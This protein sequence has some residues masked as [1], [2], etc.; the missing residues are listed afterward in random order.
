MSELPRV[1]IAS[2]VEGLPVAEAVNIKL[3]YDVRVKQWDNA[4]DL[5]SITVTSLISRANETDY[6]VFV[7]HKDDK[8]TIRGNQYSVVR[9]NV[10]FELGLF[11]GALGIDHCFL[12]IPKS[13]EGEFRLPTDLAG[14]TTSTYDDDL[15]DMVDAVATSCAKIKQVIRKL[16]KIN[17]ENAEPVINASA[18]QL[19]KQLNAKQSE[20]WRLNQDLERT[21]E[22]HTEL[23]TSIT[24]FFFTVAK[25]ATELEV[26]KWEEGA[27]DNYS[28]P[29]KVSR[30]GVYFVDKDVVIPP[31]FGS[32]SI[33]V[34]VAPNVTVHGLGKWSHNKIYYMDGFRKVE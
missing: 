17:A 19:E 15:D 12:L 31:L 23:L 3:E 13:N 5:S 26:S 21:R 1:F 32:N 2:S 22:E 28:T 30:R 10:V 11:I 4:F 25:P 24:S 8:T 7:F 20:V 33:S 9:D 29:P 34:I 6:G 14:V 27:K 16:S 18:G